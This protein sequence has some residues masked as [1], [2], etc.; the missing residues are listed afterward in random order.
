[1]YKSFSLKAFGF[2]FLIFADPDKKMV[3]AKVDEIFDTDIYDYPRNVS[4]AIFK[5]RGWAKCSPHDHFD[6]DLGTDIA[7]IRL[8]KTVNGIKNSYHLKKM[9]SN[10]QVVKAKL[11]SIKHRIIKNNPTIDLKEYLKDDVLDEYIKASTM[12]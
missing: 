11:T 5:V 3:V 12:K 7:I 2:K 9:E 10:K 4:D 8:I 6:V 1:M